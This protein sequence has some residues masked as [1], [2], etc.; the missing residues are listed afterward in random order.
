MGNIFWGFFF[1]LLDFNLTFNNVIIGL[2]PT[3]IGFF[4]IFKGINQLQDSAANFRK[5]KPWVIVMAILFT[6]TYVMDLLGMYDHSSGFNVAFG[7]LCLIASLYIQYRIIRGIQEI[8]QVQ[9]ADLKSQALFSVW[10]IV[11]ASS[12]LSFLSLLFPALALIFVLVSAIASIIFLIYL[13]QSKN[14]YE[15]TLQ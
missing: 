9:D 2:I 13:Y 5:I 11:A 14:L 3:F 10:L 12:A 4:L 6:I 15:N 8:E 7:I 1:V